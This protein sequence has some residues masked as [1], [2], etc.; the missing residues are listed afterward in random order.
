MSVPKTSAF[1]DRSVDDRVGAMGVSVNSP[2]APASHRP[3]DV[4]D[5]LLLVLSDVLDKAVVGTVLLVLSVATMAVEVV[6]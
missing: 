6:V 5:V 4:L 2:Q 3:G 1:K